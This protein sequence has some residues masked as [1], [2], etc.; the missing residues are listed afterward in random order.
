MLSLLLGWIYFS[1][2]LVWLF[3]LYSTLVLLYGCNVF[4]YHSILLKCSSSWNTD[5]V[6][7]RS[8]YFSF[9]FLHFKYLVIC[10]FSHLRVRP[11]TL[12]CSSV[13]LRD[14]S[15]LQC[16]SLSSFPFYRGLLFRTIQIFQRRVTH[17]VPWIFW[18]ILGTGWLSWYI[19][20]A[21]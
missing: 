9:T 10:D 18:D 12:I 17:Y 7:S 21:G 16:S 6:F 2:Y 20:R 19:L 11:I 1:Y 15:W 14:V 5:F 13:H 4:C 3:L 8:L